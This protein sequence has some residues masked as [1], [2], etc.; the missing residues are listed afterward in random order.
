MLSNAAQDEYSSLAGCPNL[1]PEAWETKAL[2]IRVVFVNLR[3]QLR[4]G[5]ER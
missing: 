3:E 1:D 4:T 5:S 2:S